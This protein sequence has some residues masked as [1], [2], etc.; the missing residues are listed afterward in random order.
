MQK[1]ES[2]SIMNNANAFMASFCEVENNL[3][4]A[5]LDML[6]T[7]ASNDF[8][9]EPFLRSSPKLK[10]LHLERMC[11]D[12]K[13]TFSV[14]AKYCPNLFYL[15]LNHIR[16]STKSS[17]AKD[18]G[19]FHVSFTHLKVS[20]L[21]PSFDNNYE[22]MLRLTEGK[23]THLEVSFAEKLTDA[24]YITIR[25]LCPHLEHFKIDEKKEIFEGEDERLGR[26]DRVVDIFAAKGIPICLTLWP[27]WLA[28]K[29][30]E[31]FA[32]TK[33]VQGQSTAKHSC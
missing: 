14:I 28:E 22:K 12:I 1:L 11:L 25:D 17:T 3:L 13:T 21:I 4:E 16:V 23:L 15:H 30:K 6:H 33:E 27:G 18:P 29:D 24:G 10:I 26:V 7:T 32:Y 9:L 31:A 8:N 20:T 2:I 5:S 19:P